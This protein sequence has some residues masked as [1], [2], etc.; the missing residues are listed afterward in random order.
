MQIILEVLLKGVDGVGI[1]KTIKWSSGISIILRIELENTN[2]DF[3]IGLIF[4][5]I[6]FGFLNLNGPKVKI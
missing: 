4:N 1:L 5:F 2:P 3:L 6:T